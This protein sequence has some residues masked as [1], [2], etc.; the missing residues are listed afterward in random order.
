[1]ANMNWA[2]RCHSSAPFFVIP[3]PRHW[4]PAFLQSHRKRCILTQNTYFYA[5]QLNKIPG[6]QCP[7]TCIWDLVFIMHAAT[8]LKL[9]FLDPS[10][11]CC[12]ATYE[13]LTIVRIL[14]NLL[15]ILF[16]CNQSDQI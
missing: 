6:S 16:F 4:D 5:Y 2:G 7:D 12:I 15:K 14:S 13:R 3:V 11:L 9:N 10:G 8:Y 1:M